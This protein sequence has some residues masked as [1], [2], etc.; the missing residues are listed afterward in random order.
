MWNH[1]NP[2]FVCAGPD[3]HYFKSN[4]RA[5]AENDR[6]CL[7]PCPTCG[8]GLTV[9]S[10]IE[11]LIAHSREVVPSHVPGL[12]LEYEDPHAA[13]ERMWR[14]FESRIATSANR[15]RDHEPKT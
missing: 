13:G 14:E 5:L 4:I 8:A 3:A 12:V 6:L 10:V 15:G 7:A 11:K 9:A 1:H 2:T